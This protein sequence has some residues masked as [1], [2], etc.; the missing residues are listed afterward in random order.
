MPSYGVAEK[1]LRD[2]GLETHPDVVTVIDFDDRKWKRTFIRNKK[3][4]K[5]LSP[6]A[7]DESS[8]GYAPLIGRSLKARMPKGR[9]T[10]MHASYKFSEEIGSEPEHMFFRYYLR[11]GDDWDQSRSGGKMPGFAGTY[12]KAGWG[13]RRA[14]GKN[15]WS[16]RGAFLRT[17][18]SGNPLAGRTPLGSYVYHVRQQG[19]HG[20]QW[21]WT[22][23]NPALLAQNRWYCIEQE[24]RLN[25]P[26]QE[27]G[28]LRVW[29]D[30]SLVFEKTNAYFRKTPKLRIEE[31]WFNVFHGGRHPSPHNQSY[32]IDQIVIARSYIGPAVFGND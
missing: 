19:P 3:W 6:M 20:D 22:G 4:D 27:D 32:Y 18:P 23:K 10:S 1:F 29:L 11:L 24:L 2:Q 15:G 8:D 16:A 30:G 7:E 12:G 14:N 13:G 9:S 17:L 25:T 28:V 26:G 31:V 5:L 21:V